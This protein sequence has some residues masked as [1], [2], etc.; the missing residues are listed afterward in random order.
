VLPLLY[1]PCLSHFRQSMKSAIL[2]RLD[3]IRTATWESDVG[4]ETSIQTLSSGIEGLDQCSG[5]VLRFLGSRICTVKYSMG[6]YRL[7]S[8][9]ASGSHICRMECLTW[10]CPRERLASYWLR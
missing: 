10:A 8:A 9:I 7:G 3:I 4:T 1:D 5:R 2:R 6:I